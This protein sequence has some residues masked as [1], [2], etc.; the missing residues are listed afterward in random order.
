MGMKERVYHAEQKEKTK[1]EKSEDRALEQS[2]CA[3]CISDRT[4][5]HR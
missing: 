2:G 4:F 3:V 1:K 5:D